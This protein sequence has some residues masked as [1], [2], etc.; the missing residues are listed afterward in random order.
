MPGV[1]GML[2]QRIDTAAAEAAIRLA[3]PDH[4]PLARAGLPAVKTAIPIQFHAGRF[5]FDKGLTHGQAPVL[6]RVVDQPVAVKDGAPAVRI[7]QNDDPCIL[8]RNMRVQPSQVGIDMIRQAKEISKYIE[9]MYR[10]LVNKEPFHRLEIGLSVEIGGSAATVTRPKC[11]AD[12]VDAAKRPVLDDRLQ[13]P[14]PGLETEIVVN[15]QINARL[16][17]VPCH[18]PRRVKGAAERLLAYDPRYPGGNRL[19]DH[20]HMRVRWCRDV[21]YVDLPAVQERGKV[22]MALDP[23][24]DGRARVPVGDGNKL[25]ACRALPGGMVKLRKIAGAG[26]GDAESLGRHDSSYRSIGAKGKVRDAADA[27]LGAAFALQ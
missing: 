18:M 8:T 12:L 13:L 20:R 7:A 17:R 19:F 24:R 14:V 5:G 21:Q 9:K 10:R 26:A 16:C 11:E 27:F 25:R 3:G 4:L 22:A 23:L 2:A 1:N 15:N 6:G